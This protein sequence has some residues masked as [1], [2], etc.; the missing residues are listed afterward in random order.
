MNKITTAPFKFY[1]NITFLVSI[2]VGCSSESDKK[3]ND[4]SQNRSLAKDSLELTKEVEAAPAEKPN[5][6]I[7]P[8]KKT[9]LSVSV[10][11]P[12]GGE[13][14]K[15]EPLYNKTWN[16]SVEPNGKINEKFDFLFYESVQPDKWQYETGWSIKRQ[17]LKDFFEKNMDEYG[18]SEKEIKDFTDYWVPLLNNFDYYI[19]YPQEK[20]V[21]DELI[22]I[23]FSQKPEQFL[24][25]FY[26]IQGVDSH[27]TIQ[28][29]IIKENFNRTGYFAAEWGVIRK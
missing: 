28:E 11:F 29:H 26:V 7:Y 17:E 16:V 8:T 19:I 12:Q 13:V 3:D 18:F 5:L 20:N 1:I 22:Q 10:S 21:I 24:R 25:L 4:S 6:Y 14:I 15:S 9:E 23:K 2:I 27:Q